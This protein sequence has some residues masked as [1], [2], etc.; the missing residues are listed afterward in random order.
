MSNIPMTQ[1][2]SVGVYKDT[3]LI[4]INNKRTSARVSNKIKYFPLEL[5]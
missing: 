1:I 3:N 5:E 4:M 2:K